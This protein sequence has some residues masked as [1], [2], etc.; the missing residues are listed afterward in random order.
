M[1]CDL[2]DLKM[3]VHTFTLHEIYMF[4]QIILMIAFIIHAVACM[5]I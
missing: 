2:Y 3:N 5:N 1:L 4:L